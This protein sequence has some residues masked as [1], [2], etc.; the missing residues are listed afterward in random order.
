MRNFLPV[1]IAV[2]ML[3]TTANAQKPSFDGQRVFSSE[4]GP[5]ARE[6]QYPEISRQTPRFDVYRI[7]DK[8]F[9]RHVLEA[10]SQSEFQFNFGDQSWDFVIWKNELRAPQYVHRTATDNGIQFLEPAPTSTYA[11]YVNGD[12]NNWVRINIRENHIEGII[13]S[14]GVA[15]SLQSVSIFENNLNKNSQNDVVVY[16][17]ADLVDMGVGCG[18]HPEAPDYSPNNIREYKDLQDQNQDQNLAKK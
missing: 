3:T 12:R 8:A 6:A 7:D 11:G 17:V 10:E 13:H 5:E 9:F 16:K 18:G 14:N 15:W 4:S 1:C 2:A